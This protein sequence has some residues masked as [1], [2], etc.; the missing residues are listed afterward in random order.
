MPITNE[1]ILAA[2]QVASVAQDRNIFLARFFGA[3]ELLC[4]EDTRAR[5]GEIFDSYDRK[6]RK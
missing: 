3:I 1:Q 6:G 4:D 2:A 5:I